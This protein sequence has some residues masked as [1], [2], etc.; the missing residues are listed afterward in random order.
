M[1]NDKLERP[2]VYT[3]TRALKGPHSFVKDRE[4][5]NE[6]V[7]LVRQSLIPGA[8]YFC[9]DD[10]M[11]WGRNLSLLDEMPPKSTK[12]DIRLAWRT[13]TIIGLIRHCI[14]LD[15]DLM[16]IGCYRGDTVARV[17]DAVDL[18][19]KRYWLYDLFGHEAGDAKIKA[20]ASRETMESW[21]RARFEGAPINVVA[22]SVPQTLQESGPDRVCFAHIDL[23]NAEPEV[24][25]LAW[26]LPRMTPGG[27]IV[28]DDYGWQ[29]L[30]DQKVAIDQYL[31]DRKVIELPTGQGL[32]LV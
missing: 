25:A 30:S 9:T 26:V 27:A 22:G 12:T 2:K 24:E 19:D 32:L 1:E 10:M 20:D 28:F 7:N 29:G 17:R 21:V 14:T 16:E 3:Q 4:T 13:Y 18:G 15:G 8:S 6:G 31:K 23:N 11:V 5:F